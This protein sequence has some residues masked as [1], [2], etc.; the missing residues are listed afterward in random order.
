MSAPPEARQ[1]YTIPGWQ[2]QRGRQKQFDKFIRKSSVL[3]VYKKYHSDSYFSFFIQK[4]HEYYLIDEIK[5][6]SD[7][8]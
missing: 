7:E 2:G 1:I 5:I 4:A 8:A 3:T 6:V